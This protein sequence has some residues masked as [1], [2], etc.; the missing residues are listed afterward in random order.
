MWG[1]GDVWVIGWALG[2]G[3]K[4]FQSSWFQEKVPASYDDFDFSKKHP[5]LKIKVIFFST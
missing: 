2:V 4:K 3:D 1:L 5:I